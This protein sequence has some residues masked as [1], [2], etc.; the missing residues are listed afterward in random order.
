MK[1]GQFI[2]SSRLIVLIMTNEVVGNK[3][4]VKASG[5]VRTFPDTLAMIRAGAS[6][7]GTMSL[8]LLKYPSVECKAVLTTISG[9]S[10]GMDIVK[11]GKEVE[12]GKDSFY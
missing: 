9:T 1:A 11:G 7:I 3:A 5:G 4:Q 8:F 2:C 12:R 6:R 10:S